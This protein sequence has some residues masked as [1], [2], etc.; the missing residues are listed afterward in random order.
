MMKIGFSISVLV[1]WSVLL[2]LNIAAKCRV[3]DYCQ[4]N[5]ECKS[6][7][8]LEEISKAAEECMKA[9]E[10]SLVTYVRST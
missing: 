3:F 4:P 10:R 1:V 7:K 9:D 5:G 8:S 6:Y 2:G